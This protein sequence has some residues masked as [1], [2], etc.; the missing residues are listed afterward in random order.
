M[1]KVLR[2]SFV[3]IMC[4][5]YL[6]TSFLIPIKAE[7]TLNKGVYVVSAELAT[8]EY[9][10]QGADPYRY[11]IF[12]DIYTNDINAFGYLEYT[13]TLNNNTYTNTT[14]YTGL[15]TRKIIYEY[16][17]V[18]SMVNTRLG[19]GVFDSDS[20]SI[21]I[22]N[23]SDDTI[24]AIID[25]LSDIDNVIDTI[26][27][28]TIENAVL[29]YSLT[30]N[31]PLINST[32]NIQQSNI[33]VNLPVTN[34]LRRNSSIYHLRLGIDKVTVSPAIFKGNLYY[35]NTGGEKIDIEGNIYIQQNRQY[36]D[37]YIYNMR[38]YYES[39]MRLEL[40]ISNG[41][42]YVYNITNGVFEYIKDTDIEYWQ[43]LEFFETHEYY[44]NE[45]PSLEDTN[46]DLDPVIDDYIQTE[47]S[48]INDFDNAMTDNS[49]NPSTNTNANTST[50]GN[51]YT[52]SIGF[53]GFIYNELL[54]SSLGGNPLYLMVNFS[55]MLGLALLIIGKRA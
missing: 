33:Y 23:L 16:S 25:S 52:S 15:H 13:Y 50:W 54:N 39:N 37:I 10:T 11:N 32:G 7:T 24:N 38:L 51:L 45:Y 9:N 42:L 2:M 17:T 36:I 34:D 18:S 5:T 53:V 20:G 46:E 27:W 14:S 22:V 12:I 35:I 21:Q 44:Q 30:W 3:L 29:Q 4:V 48:L 26:S 47:D 43:L 40:S 55:L 49:V 31:G 41:N 19:N 28:T 1:K 6:F 8:V